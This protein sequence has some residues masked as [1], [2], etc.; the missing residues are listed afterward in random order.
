MRHLP[1]IQG[2]LAQEIE[3]F[4]ARIPKSRAQLASGSR[5]MPHGVPMTWMAGL[6]RHAAL[7]VERGEGAYFWDADNNKFMDVNVADYAAYCGYANPAITRAVT[8]RAMKGCTF[9]LPSEDAITVSRLLATRCAVPYWQYT[10]SATQAVIEAIRLA[11]MVTGR[12]QVLVFE[13]CYHGHLDEIMGRDGHGVQN[14]QGHLGLL[15]DSGSKVT[16]VPFNDLDAVSSALRT[17]PHACL[18]AEPAMTNYGLIEPD[19]GFWE[20]CAGVARET[21]TLLILDETHTLALAPSGLR[22]TYKLAPDM[23]VLGKGL[24]SGVP[25]GAY[26][27]SEFLAKDFA[28]HLDR[29]VE[30]HGLLVGN[31]MAGNTLSLAAARAA[32][33]TVLVPTNYEKVAMRGKRLADGLTRLFTSHRLDWCA[34]HVGGRSSWVLAPRPPRNATESALSLDRDLIAA[35]RLFMANRGV[36]DA[37][38]SAGP[39]VGFMHE[40]P[41]V[42]HYLTVAE[43]FLKALLGKT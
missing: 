14:Y 28:K 16:S 41:E 32:L 36:W 37:I 1:R 4:Q 11:R 38:W 22:A 6:Y 10:L 39:T 15:K 12:E 20:A 21:G 23:V 18:I 9:L 42:D 7:F 34:P 19:S 24:G 40:T 5:H 2:I 3:Q 8:E 27:M 25:L 35:R 26:G 31:T 17:Y 43:D 33:A 13:G 30:P 29:D